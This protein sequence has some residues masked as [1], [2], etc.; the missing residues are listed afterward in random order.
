MQWNAACGNSAL[1]AIIMCK[2][3]L[4]LSLSW[5]T[6]S[7]GLKDEKGREGKLKDYLIKP[8]CIH[9]RQKLKRRLKKI[10]NAFLP[11]DNV[12]CRKLA[13]W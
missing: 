6:N 11:V 5:W 9:K 4:N 8:E 10:Y 13:F 3:K 7:Y 12:I 2:L 1:E